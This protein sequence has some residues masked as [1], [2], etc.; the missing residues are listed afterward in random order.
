MSDQE[1]L[2]W[3]RQGIGSSDAAVL[4]NGSH[5]GKT[6]HKLYW[7]KISDEI[8]DEDNVAMRHG[9]QHEEAALDWFEN[10]MDCVL[11]RQ[12]QSVSKGKEWIRATI[13]GLDMEGQ[14]LVE[15]KC[16]YNLENHHRVKRSRE[17]PPIY[18]PQ[19]QHL[20]IV[21]NT[22]YMYF[23]SFNHQDP[24]DSIIIRVER[25]QKYIEK[26]L[27]IYEKFWN[28]V[29][30]KTPP[31]LSEEDYVPM[32]SDKSWKQ[33]SAQVLKI[34]KQKKALEEKEQMTIESLKSLSQGQSAK[35]HGISLQK[36]ICV[37]P[38]DY[39]I[40]P[41]LK[42]VDTT[43]YRKNSFEKWTLRAIK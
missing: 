16:P 36:Q 22:E 9:R 35:G 33:L 34:R 39:S 14:Y 11:F 28:C 13:D 3:R 21:R 10:T 4:I 8:V 18:Y 25:D 29:K 6:P 27:E 19:C 17:V 23:E 12:I 26:S 31:P 38:I 24:S 30:N 42:G 37:G 15:A 40:I 43:Q 7:E 41:E 5:F 32:D 2:S 20:M 1:W